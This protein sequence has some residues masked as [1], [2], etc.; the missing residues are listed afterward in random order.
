[1]RIR[2]WSSDVCS[3]DLVARQAYGADGR[4]DF[5]YDA[6]KRRFVENA[7]QE[8]GD[9]YKRDRDQQKGERLV[10]QV[11]R[12]GA[13]EHHHLGAA[14][15][16]GISGRHQHNRSA[17]HTSELQSLMRIS[18]AVFCSKTKTDIKQPRLNHTEKRTLGD[19]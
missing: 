12:N 2:D 18:Y 11:G 6:D 14:E 5:E 1:M 15:Y 3:S 8:H 7:D 19:K 17:E 10:N 9:E 16:V 4:H 13:L